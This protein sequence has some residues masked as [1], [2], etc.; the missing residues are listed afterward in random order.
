M[1]FSLGKLPMAANN[2][3]EKRKERM[4]IVALLASPRTDGN[5]STLANRLT[6]AAA[7]KGAEVQAF[8]LNSL[9]YRGCQA[10]NAC[11]LLTDHCVLNDDL[12]EVLAEVAKADVLVLATPVYYG[13]VTGQLK[14][15]IDRSFS[16]Y[17]PDFRTSC[18]P[19]RLASGKKLIFIQT[20]GNPDQTFF[21]DIYSRYST[22]F[23]RY[24]FDDS[25][26]VRACGVSEPGQ[27]NEN[28]V[29]L[30]RLD[31][32]TAQLFPDGALSW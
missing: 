5:S 19:S 11:K 7:A 3:I 28:Q 21:G 9:N 6:S 13:D 31:S 14:L 10:C 17:T 16:Y 29:V 12:A 22:F 23:K 26:L 2:I 4:K 25:S 27:V 15:F 18:K 20:Q 32:V 24:G 30:D 8:K 1:M